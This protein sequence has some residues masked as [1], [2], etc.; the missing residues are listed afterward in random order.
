LA[1]NKKVIV[2]AKQNADEPARRGAARPHFDQG[3]ERMIADLGDAAKVMT[4]L[5]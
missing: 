2:A 3:K 4:E 5:R 1:L